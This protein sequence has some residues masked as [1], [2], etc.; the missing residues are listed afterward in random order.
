MTADITPLFQ[1]LTIGDMQLPN[2]FVMAP[3]TRCRAINHMPNALMKEYY[4]QRASA[5]LIITEC[6][7]VSPGTSAFAHEPGIYNDEQVAAWKEITDAVHARGGRIFMQIWHAGRAAVPALNNNQAPVSAEPTAISGTARTPVGE[8]P[9]QTPEALTEAGIREIIEDFRTGAENARKAGFDGVEIHAANGYLIDQF[10]R[11]GSNHRDDEY[12]NHWHGRVK[13]LTD[14]LEAVLSVW[15]NRHVGIRISPLNGFNDMKDSDPVALVRYLCS[16]LN[17]YDLAYLHIMRGDFRGEQLADVV[18]PAT[19][20]Y[21]GQL[22]VN[23]GYTPDE[24]AEALA[25]HVADLVS[26]GSAFIANPDL[27]ERVRTHAP[28][29]TPDPATFYSQGPEGYTDYPSLSA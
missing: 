21:K 6:T 2:R 1:P 9:Y 18:S 8:F 13:L 5:G 10:L 16:H 23:M 22:M 14:V 27:P 19:E 29:N 7:M 4:T 25:D 15:D 3:L 11:D 26:F 12:G 20:I 24:A 28:L 17:P